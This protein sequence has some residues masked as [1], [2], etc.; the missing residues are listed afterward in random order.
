MIK[1]KLISRKNM[2]KDAE[3]DST[4]LYPQLVS[5][6]RVSLDDLPEVQ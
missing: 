3:P 6:G 2:K 4:L 1:Y 5:N